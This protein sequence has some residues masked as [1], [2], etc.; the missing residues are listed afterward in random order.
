MDSSKQVAAIISN[1]P[2]FPTKQE[3]DAD[4]FA[5]LKWMHE[6]FTALLPT[7]LLHFWLRDAVLYNLVLLR[8]ADATLPALIARPLSNIAELTAGQIAQDERN[9]KQYQIIDS[10]YGDILW[11]KTPPCVRQYMNSTGVATAALKFETHLATFNR[12]FLQVGL[13]QFDTH[14][15][16]FGNTINSISQLLTHWQTI[17]VIAAQASRT[18]E[19]PYAITILARVLN[20]LG[21]ND[22]VVRYHTKRLN[23]M[24]PAQRAE[25]VDT[26]IAFVLQSQ[27]LDTY[28]TANVIIQSGIAN[29]MN[30]NSTAATTELS[31]QEQ[32]AHL[33][34]QIGN[35]TSQISKITTGNHVADVTPNPAIPPTRA[36]HFCST[37]GINKSHVSKDCRKQT[38]GH[39]LADTHSNW[40][41][42]AQWDSIMERRANPADHK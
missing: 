40:S 42:K 19:H 38:P 11:N 2:Q 32:V 1:W 34:K 18:F 31:M 17:K 36:T 35:L 5:Y 9:N 26:F 14:L 16:S 37:H 22:I 24:F 8:P 28:K 21:Q 15:L 12:M 33:A 6:T 3:L 20:K 25:N 4:P 10:L 7:Q 30:R 41:N 27:T 23:E 13:Q 29:A 39:N